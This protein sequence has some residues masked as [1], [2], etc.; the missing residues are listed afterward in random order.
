[1]KSLSLSI[2]LLLNLV[3]G[4]ERNRLPDSNLSIDYGT[5]IT[6]ESKNFA[7]AV[8]WIGNCSATIV[9]DNTVITAAHCVDSFSQNI[10][11]S[12]NGNI[13]IQT[14]YARGKTSTSLHMPT[15]YLTETNLKMAFDI[16]V[17]VFPDNSF[18]SYHAVSTEKP[19]VGDDLTLV[20]YSPY[21][22]GIEIKD[23]PI[24]KRWG[25]NKIA[26]FLSD[27]TIVS[28]GGCNRQDCVTVSPGDSGGP[29][30]Q[31]CKLLG[32][33]SRMGGPV[34]SK[35]SLHTNTT[36]EGVSTWL[37]S[38]R[39]KGAYA[40]GFHGN[41]A[42]RCA[43]D[44]K[45][46][47]TPASAGL[48]Q[49]TFTCSVGVSADLTPNNDSQPNNALPNQPNQPNNSQNSTPGSGTPAPGASDLNQCACGVT[50]NIYGSGCVVERTKPT[51][52]QQRFLVQSGS[53]R[54]CQ[55]E[56]LCRANYG[57]YLN[58]K[59]WCPDGW[60]FGKATDKQAQ[61][62]Q[63]SQPNQPGQPNGNQTPPSGGAAPGPLLT[64]PQSPSLLKDYGASRNLPDAVKGAFER[65]IK[66][67]L[68]R[69]CSECHHPGSHVDLI[70]AQQIGKAALMNAVLLRIEANGVGMMPPAPRPRL[71]SEEIQKIR[72]WVQS[73]Q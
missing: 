2:A 45:F 42:Q 41:D 1:M 29:A 22:D 38:M 43:P 9:S 32:V 65:D 72:S 71:T 28:D 5:G 47:P 34:S 3:F 66:P 19:K 48:D 27:I 37:T 61:P 26:R 10:D 18:K 59:Q 21:K 39:A 33:A 23:A 56:E 69:T 50:T 52:N 54:M 55:T 64:P 49:N 63:P 31:Q 14:G 60:F 70:G 68:V 36:Y 6:P 30:F 17:A 44:K 20:G 24:N 12:L 67:I 8:V 15:R 53:S 51:A 58:D 62:G 25:T 40:C 7:E 4:C 35:I 57:D 11:G 46:G 13:S 16:A 73:A